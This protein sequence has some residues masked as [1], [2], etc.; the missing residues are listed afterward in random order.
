MTPR[1]LH[2]TQVTKVPLLD[3]VG[4]RLGRVSDVLVRISD[5]GYAPVVGITANVSGRDVFLPVDLIAAIEPG[6]MRLARERFDLRRFERRPGEVLLREDVLGR[7]LIN[8]TGAHLVRA[9]E[10]ELAR[11]GDRWCVVGIDT[12][13]GA[14]VRRLLPRSKR[15][16]P[17]RPFLDWT[18][19]RPFLSHVPGAGD[20]LPATELA[21]LHPAQIA[22][23]VEAASHEE[24]QEIIN[25]VRHN[26]ELEADVFEEMD[27]EHQ[28]EFLDDRSDEDTANLIGR[29]APD[30]A[31]DLIMEL[32]QGRRLPVLELL[33]VT[34]QRKVRTLL[35]F[36]PST[37][38]GMMGLDFMCLDGRTAVGAAVAAIRDTDLAPE[39]L[40]TIFTHDGSGRL[41]GA[42]RLARLLRHED[43]VLLSDVAESAPPHLNTDAEV[44][45]IAVIMSDYN[46]TI[47][48]VVDHEDRVLGVVTVDDLL[49]TLIPDEWKRRAEAI[50][51]G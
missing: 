39:A 40:Q 44:S 11:I 21:R 9:N 43:D 31:A 12:S 22:D 29:M 35:G 2:L 27:V 5:G 42:I 30:D 28:L 48:P 18:S 14:L 10:I 24:G 20:G 49:E 7:R 50:G 23:L 13:F 15:Q 17:V 46:L 51:E 41:S 36:H 37:A 33:P 8:L 47:I 26:S 32:D 25:A 16:P 38:G 6:K 3:R 4:D 34:H 19:V 1:I 45:D